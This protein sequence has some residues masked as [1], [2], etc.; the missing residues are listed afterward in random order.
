MS[1][2]H[3]LSIFAMIAGASIA[4]RP[5]PAVRLNAEAGI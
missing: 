1:T 4:V 2:T 5:T 3:D